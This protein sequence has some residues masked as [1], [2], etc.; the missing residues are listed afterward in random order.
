MYFT[1]GG[2]VTSAW[3]NLVQ[4]V[5][6]WGGFLLA[7]PLVLKDAGG[8][9]ALAQ[10]APASAE[11]YFGFFHG[12]GSGWMC[13]S[14]RADQYV[15]VEAED[16]TEDVNEIIWK[17]WTYLILLGPAFIVSPGLVQKV[18]GA[19]DER[20]IRLGVGAS[21]V[22]LIVFAAI[23]PLLGMLAHVYA[24]TLPKVDLALP[25]VL[26][27]ALPPAVGSLAL[28]AV[29]SAELSSADA[30]LF[31]LSTSLSQDLYKRFVRPAATDRQVLVVSRAAAVAGGILGVALAIALPSVISSLT[32]FYTLLT[33]SLFVPVAAGLH[34]RRAGT[35]EALAAIAGG[36]GV[37][38]L[39]RAGSMEH[40]VWNAG[41]VGL[42]ASAAVFFTLYAAR[43][44]QGR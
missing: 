10:S 34:S 37:V 16:G 2:L 30:I 13:Q 17:G 9:S 40:G 5:V 28:A 41:T 39:M 3:V 24:P 18:Y 8:W 15:W 42:L 14:A 23:P 35:M 25:T 36:V 22:A 43:R 38:A 7:L 20:A 27:S 4:L 33:V 21:A 19:R 6:L 12:G 1:A 44:I 11:H 31:M 26:T 29:F 32:I